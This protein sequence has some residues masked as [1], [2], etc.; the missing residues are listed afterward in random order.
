MFLIA[1][2]VYLNP[3]FGINVNVGDY[4][5]YFVTW[6]DTGSINIGIPDPTPDMMALSKIKIAENDS[7]TLIE[8]LTPLEEDL[9]VQAKEYGWPILK[10]L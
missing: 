10:K 2:Y 3:V 9:L 4:K 8:D 1:I 7:S 6:E 5:K